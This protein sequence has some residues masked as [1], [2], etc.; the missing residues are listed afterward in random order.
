[1]A[2]NYHSYCKDRY[3]QLLVGKLAN[4]LSHDD[5][6]TLKDVVSDDYYTRRYGTIDILK[7]IDVINMASGGEAYDMNAV[8]K[9]MGLEYRP[10]S[11]D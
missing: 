9:T 11:Q 10:A 7:A 3:F 4:D 5:D 6:R 1:M 8:A 2:V